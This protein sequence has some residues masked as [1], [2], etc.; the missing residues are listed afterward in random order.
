MCAF[1]GHEI[2]AGR[3]H[4]YNEKTGVPFDTRQ[5][6]ISSSIPELIH[7]LLVE[8]DD[9]SNPVRPRSQECSSEVQ[10]PLLLAETG[11][12]N[13]ADARCIQEAEGVELIRLLALLL[14]LF[15]CLLGKIDG[16][17]EVH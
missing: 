6:C 9:S 2:Y 15:D 1:K 12:G 17:E 10:G 8:L 14:R 11:A 13:D 16:G 5:I 7:K 4:M 3:K